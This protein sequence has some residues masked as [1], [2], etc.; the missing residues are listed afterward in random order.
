MHLDILL[1][2]VFGTIFKMNKR[3]TQVNGQK[4]K[5]IDEYGAGETSKR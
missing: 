2:K 1:C 3:G 5:K 4:E